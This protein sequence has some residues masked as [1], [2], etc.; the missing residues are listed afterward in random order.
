MTMTRIPRGDV[1]PVGRRRLVSSGMLVVTCVTAAFVSLSVP[2]CTS[3]PTA[4]SLDGRGELTNED[5]GSR[6]ETASGAN[7]AILF[8]LARDQSTDAPIADLQSGKC[9]EFGCR[10]DDASDCLS[11]FCVEFMDGQVCST[12]CIEDCPQGWQC[13]QTSAFGDPI[14]ICVSAF[15]GLCRP[16]ERSSDCQSVGGVANVCVRHED[17]DGNGLVAAFCGADCT[18]DSDCPST[19]ECGDSVSIEG[20]ASR[21]CRPQEGLCACSDTSVKLGLVAACSTTSDAGECSGTR[22]CTAEGLADCSAQ[23]PEEEICDG[24]DNDCSGAADD[25]IADCCVCG[26]GLCHAHCESV[27]TCCDDCAICGNG[28]CECGESYCDCE[29]DCCGTCGDGKCADYLFSSGLHCCSEKSSCSQ[30]CETLPCGDSVCGDGE[31][32]WNCPQDCETMVCGNGVCEQVVG[33]SAES[34]PQDCDKFCG[35]CKCDFEKGEIGLKCPVDCGFCGDSYCSEC[36]AMGEWDAIQEE[37]LCIDCCDPA[38]VCKPEGEAPLSCGSDGCGGVCGLCE[39]GLSCTTDTCSQGQCQHELADGCLIA[40]ICYSTGTP[41]LDNPCQACNPDTATAEWSDVQD[42]TVCGKNMLCQDGICECAFL[43]CDE[44]CCSDGAVCYDDECCKPQCQGKEC[45][46][47]GCGGSCGECAANEMC[48]DIFKCVCEPDSIL[49]NGV[50]CGAGEICHAEAGACCLPQ[51][52]GLECGNDGCGWPDGCGTC[53]PDSVDCWLGGCIPEGQCE[54]DGHCDYL[55]EDYPCLGLEGACNMAT[56]LCR[57]P[58]V[59]PSSWGLADDTCLLEVRLLKGEAG[60][61]WCFEAGQAHPVAV[62]ADFSC[63][64]CE[65][66]HPF[67]WTP[68]F[69]LGVDHC[70]INTEDDVVWDVFGDFPEPAAFPWTTG[71][72]IAAATAAPPG[73][74]AAWPHPQS[75]PSA[76]CL[77]CVPGT[78]RFAWSPTPEWS[79]AWSVGDPNPCPAPLFLDGEGALV[80]DSYYPSATAGRCADG[81]CWG[82]SLLPLGPNAGSTV[83]QVVVDESPQHLVGTLGGPL[84]G[85]VAHYVVN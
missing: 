42:G 45:G 51:C 48:N 31:N 36:P 83:Y 79:P 53:P 38:V 71:E 47:D 29:I 44:A 74:A 66:N 70:F 26:D 3:S 64:R 63:L 81:V 5:S 24:I 84:S 13:K 76:T 14:S 60:K 55:L 85:G 23:V 16:C 39:D 18:E 4:E 19:F 7:D 10:C 30:D 61:A 77:T 49:C 58:Q 17:L 27:E 82:L 80:Q 46:S 11:G 34:C 68:G 20:Q 6:S 73:D 8:D 59:A 28:V 21:Q 62:D 25:G 40:G 32:P 67:V 69:S 15:A 1:A 57:D 65:P 54:H 12:S 41:A 9:G 43:A 33:E 35:N 37:W 2:G 72:C 75:L 22:Q 52:D 50:C 56:G 78:S